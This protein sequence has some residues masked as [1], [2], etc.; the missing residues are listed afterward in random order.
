MDERFA[1][2]TG[3]QAYT[4]SELLLKGALEGGVALV[5]GY[6]GSPLADFFD[7]PPP[8]RQL[9]EESGIVFQM[10]NN[11]ARAAARLNGSQMADLKAMAVM[12]SVGAHVAADGLALGNLGKYGHRG[13]AIVVIGDDPW[14]EST[15][16][17]ADSRFIAQHLQLP[18]MEPSTFQ[19]LKDWVKTA[20]DLSAASNLFIGYL[21]TTNQADGGGTVRVFPNQPPQINRRHPTTLDSSAF[22]LEESVLLPPRTSQQ[23]AALDARFARL[24]EAAGARGIN[25]MLWQE[26]PAKV[27]F[28]ASGMA[29]C[30]LVQALDQL[31]LL[32]RFPILKLGLSYP[33]DADLVRRF[34]E[35][36]TDVVG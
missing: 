19:E 8:R 12:K 27:G 4:G 5:T 10:A 30:Y 17:P 35:G 18:V 22:S 13:G 36:L 1:Q 32:G 15:Q 16:V 29:Y 33:L 34:A 31:D 25:Q 2:A 26:A 9:L 6:P 21:V 20:F 7:I 28:V 23:E 3:T 14:N 24:L 11:E